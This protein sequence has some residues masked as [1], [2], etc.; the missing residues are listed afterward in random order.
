M[1]DLTQLVGPHECHYDHW[2]GE[3]AQSMQA[4]GTFKTFY[5]YYCALCQS[6]TFLDRKPEG[7]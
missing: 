5:G 4:D 3:K 6:R 1:E 2:D 7:A